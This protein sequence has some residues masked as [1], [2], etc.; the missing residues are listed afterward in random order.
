MSRKCIRVVLSEG[1][2]V[3]LEQWIRAGSTPQQV[4]LRAKM[5]LAGAKGQGDKAIAEELKVHRFSVGLI[6]RPY[7]EVPSKV[8]RNCTK[9]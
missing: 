7:A 8:S 9:R 1:E 3:R 2:V 4:V 6:K 5:I